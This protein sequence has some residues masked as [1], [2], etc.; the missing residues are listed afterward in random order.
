ML[1]LLITQ[2]HLEAQKELRA[3]GKL[4]IPREGASG[5]STGTVYIKVTGRVWAWIKLT[6]IAMLT[7]QCACCV[8]PGNDAR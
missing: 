3:L 1:R 6:Q 5:C 4:E 2:L 7:H 8:A